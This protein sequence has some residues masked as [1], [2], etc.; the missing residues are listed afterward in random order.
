M[1]FF[2]TKQCKPYPL[3]TDFNPYR[4]WMIN[5]DIAIWFDVFKSSVIRAV[6]KRPH[7]WLLSTLRSSMEI[8][9]SFLP[10]EPNLVA[11]AASESSSPVEQ[12]TNCYFP[13]RFPPELRP[14]FDCFQLAQEW[15]L[16]FLVLRCP[17]NQ[18]EPHNSN[19]N[20]QSIFSPPSPNSIQLFVPY[21][22]KT[23]VMNSTHTKTRLLR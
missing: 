22:I 12:T 1:F 2:E 18:Q 14:C 9:L 20:S 19:A 23:I 8:R 15:F 16:M 21:T 4:L 5:S 7:F 3:D 11:I 17:R 10:S 6:I 13:S